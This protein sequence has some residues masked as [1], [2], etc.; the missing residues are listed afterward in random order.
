MEGVFKS[1]IYEY[2]TQDN[3]EN[4]QNYFYSKYMGEPFLVSYSKIRET[5]IN[6]NKPLDKVEFP[7]LNCNTYLDLSTIKK[8]F[9]CNSMNDEL[10]KLLDAYLKS[11]EIRKKI[12]EEYDKNNKFKP[13]SEKYRVYCLYFLLAYNLA[14]AA[15]N[16][17]NL[18]YFNT[19]LKVDDTLISIYDKLCQNEQKL[20]SYILEEELKIFSYIKNRYIK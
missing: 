15:L 8:A 5:I 13:K 10:W 9:E 11:F 18:K 19:L 7:T 17:D 4:K 6:K 14:H 20:L 12:Y 2:I 1:M 16:S 3:L